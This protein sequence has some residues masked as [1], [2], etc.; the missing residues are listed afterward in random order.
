MAAEAAV[1][2]VPAFRIN[3]FVGRLSYLEELQGYGL[4][5]GFRPGQEADLL[6]ALDGV[7]SR[8][9]AATEFQARRARLLAETI[10]PLP[11]FLETVDHLM[12]GH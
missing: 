5:F 6:A 3:D 4:T 7:L 1:L 8:P 12:A 11:W 10:D 9:A 2:G